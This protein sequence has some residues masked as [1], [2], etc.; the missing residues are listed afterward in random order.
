MDISELRAVE[1]KLADANRRKDEFLAMLAHELR[2]PLAPIAS[3]AELLGMF[4]RGEPRI[5]K[6]SE[7]IVRQVKHLSALVD[8]LLDASRISRGLVELN[9]EIVNLDAAIDNAVEQAKPLFDA[10]RHALS[11]HHNASRPFV[12]GDRNR[13]VQVFANLLNNA[14]KYTPAAG[15][16]R[17]SVRVSGSRV[18]VEVE[19]NGIGMEVSLL[20]HVFELFTQAERN[21]ARSDG[22]LG[23]GLALVERI[24][25]LHGGEVIAESAGP[26]SGSKFTV[27]LPLA[28]GHCTSLDN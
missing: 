11:V 9:R 22:G 19:D 10:R 15:R 24:V 7:V 23:I 25:A 21:P 18:V 26:G 17:L 20:P 5:A 13:L 16:V 4:A 2:N 12:L 1:M 3:A 6:P 8:D 27:A 14:A 28:S